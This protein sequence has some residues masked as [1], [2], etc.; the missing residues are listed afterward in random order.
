MLIISTLPH[1]LSVLPVLP[2]YNIC[3]FGYCNIIL[4]SSSL[5]VLYHLYESNRIIYVLDYTMACIWFLYDIYMG[6]HYAPYQ[7]IV[8]N[9]A[10]G[11]LHYYLRSRVQHSIWHLINAT[12]CIYVSILIQKD[13]V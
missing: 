12:K 5:S 11:I 3:T 8:V 9:L 7:I 13:I 4:L 1:F 10:S 6:Y 2:Y